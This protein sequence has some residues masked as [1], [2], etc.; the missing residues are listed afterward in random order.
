MQ[1]MSV[2]HSFQEDEPERKILFS[3]P[4]QSGLC[5]RWNIHFSRDAESEL[6]A[7][8]YPTEQKL[9]ERTRKLQSHQ[10]KSIIG[11]LYI[12]DGYT[13]CVLCACCAFGCF[14][15]SAGG[16]ALVVLLPSSFVLPNPSLATSARL[17]KSWGKH[18]HVWGISQ[19][20]NHGDGRYT[21]HGFLLPWILVRRRRDD[22]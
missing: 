4:I 14:K 10:G 19:S 11:R 12:V 16:L 21:V 22:S 2:C 3:Y 17:T 6:I 8:S 7:A 13:W 1:R 9:I 5:L 20:W 18:M 15:S